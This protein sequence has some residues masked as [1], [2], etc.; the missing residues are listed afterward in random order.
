[1]SV[2]VALATQRSWA[3]YALGQLLLA[4]VFTHAFVLLHEAGHYTLLRSR[5]VNRLFG[6]IAG[7]IALIPFTSWQPIH[8]RHHRFT[9]WQDL[10]STTAS[11]VPRGLSRFEHAAVDFAWRWWLPLFSVLYRLQNY[12][13]VGRMALFLRDR[14]LLR[15]VRRGVIVQI[16]AYFALAASVG[17]REL[18][19][20]VG[21][22]LLVALAAQD[23]LLLSQHTH[24]PQEMSGGALVKP[25]RPIEQLPYTRT[26]RLPPALSTALLHFDLHELHHLYPNVPGYLLHRIDY[27]GPNTFEWRSWIRAAKRLPGTTFL[28][29]NRDRT[30]APL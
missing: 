14:A 20:L 3:L 21:P 12:W 8:A 22:A 1:M 18:A 25:F 26:L 17:P 16:A 15:R 28:F 11:L 9:G 27:V 13:N 7:F 4:F 10:D 24:L 23:V 6:T 2:G 29:S 5:R 30:G 19:V